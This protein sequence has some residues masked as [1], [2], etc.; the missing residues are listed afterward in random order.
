MNWFLIFIALLGLL[1]FGA[2]L[3]V[4]AALGYYHFKVFLESF[5]R[6]HYR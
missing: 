2:M 5:E 4:A 6:D 1:T 3:F